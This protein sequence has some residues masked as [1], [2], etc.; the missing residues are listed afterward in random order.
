[1][2]TTSRAVCGNRISMKR[3]AEMNWLDMRGPG[4]SDLDLFF[5]TVFGILTAAMFCVGL[6]VWWQEE[7]E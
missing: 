3:M 4:F 7:R 2:P 1:M 5:L 6:L